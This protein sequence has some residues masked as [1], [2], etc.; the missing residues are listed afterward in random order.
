MK[1]PNLTLKTVPFGSSNLYS[2]SKD[3]YSLISNPYSKEISQIAAKHKRI[4]KKFQSLVFELTRPVVTPLFDLPNPGDIRVLL[5]EATTD[6][7]IDL[8]ETDII[9]NHDFRYAYG[10]S[11][12]FITLNS[13]KEEVSK[14]RILT[15]RS[16]T[17][18]LREYIS[19][20]RTNQFLPQ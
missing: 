9:M 8:F 14:E 15:G 13:K 12:S 1:Q 10:K 3:S 16:S 19:R 7:Y 5:Q 4:F 11:L 6:W 20:I 17:I 2:L 18:V